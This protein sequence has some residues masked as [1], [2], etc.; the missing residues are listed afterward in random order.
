VADRVYLHIGVMK[1]ATTF[2]QGL[3]DANTQALSE[4]DILWP[5]SAL[6]FAA[7]GDL[8]GSHGK[9]KIG[10]WQVLEDEIRAYDGPVL[11]SNELLSI[12]RSAGAIAFA[13]RLDM[14][15]EVIV[16]A[17][18]LMRV[19]PSQWSTSVGNGR[20][21]SWEE[22]VDALVRDDHDHPDVYRLWRRQDLPGIIRAWSRITDWRPV[23]LVT[24]PAPGGSSDAIAE[25]FL[26][27]LGVELA[28]MTE[29]SLNQPPRDPK[30][31]VIP[32]TD[33]PEAWARRR[34]RKMVRRLQ[35]L[36]VDLV[37]EWDDLLP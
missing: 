26:S 3:L 15:I 8:L 5:G 18:D 27:V 25:R 9:R 7:V 34:S 21:G 37:G 23:R 31:P 16:T 10:S 28:A 6:N 30:A 4:H 1:S 32:L 11:L 14:P 24:V 20:M 2:L 19:I 36:P 12:R 33:E 35:R 17:R 29:P 22:F 13:E